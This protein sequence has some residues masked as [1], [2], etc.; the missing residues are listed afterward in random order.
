MWW[1]GTGQR[2]RRGWY[3]SI[4]NIEGRCDYAEGAPIPFTFFVLQVLD[5]Q[6]ACGFEGYSYKSF[7]ELTPLS[8]A[9]WEE[10][11]AVAEV[12]ARLTYKE[13]V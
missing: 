8:V 9:S 10:A 1:I 7:H 12:I 6:Y 4:H 13:Q 11:K 5:D 3:L 2:A